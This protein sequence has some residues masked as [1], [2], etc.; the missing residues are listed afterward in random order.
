MNFYCLIFNFCDFILWKKKKKK[1]SL[2]SSSFYSFLLPHTFDPQKSNRKNCT[3]QTEIYF[4]LF[5]KLDAFR[6]RFL[7][8]IVFSARQRTGR[9]RHL[10]KEE[11]NKTHKIKFNS[12][13]VAFVINS[14][15][16]LFF[17]FI[18]LYEKKYISRMN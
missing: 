11:R 6:I 3:N 9:S 17:S 1:L 7:V 8:C 4:I 18:S 14:H 12:K 5:C 16:S 15:F 13:M 10:E 2:F